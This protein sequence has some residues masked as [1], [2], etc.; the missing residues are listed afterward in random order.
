MT[1]KKLLIVVVMIIAMIMIG[2][3]CILP[4]WKKNAMELAL[5]KMQEELAQTIGVRIEDYKNPNVFPVGYFATVLKPGMTYVEVH[6]IVRG[7]EDVLACFS[8]EEVYYYFSTDEKTAI[9]FIVLYDNQGKFIELNGEEPGSELLINGPGE[10]ASGE[11]V[12]GLLGK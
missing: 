3:F 1:K 5:G 8:Q 2:Q 7:Y 11:C 4:A 9:R 10:L 12:H 6:Q